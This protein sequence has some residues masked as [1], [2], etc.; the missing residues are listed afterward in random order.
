MARELR[1]KQCDNNLIFGQ[2]HLAELKFKCH[3]VGF[4]PPFSMNTE[5]NSDYVNAHILQ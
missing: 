3:P 1:V 5:Q 4:Y 2:I